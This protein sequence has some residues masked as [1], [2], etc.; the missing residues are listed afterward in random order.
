MKRRKT[1][2][3][4]IIY[5]RISSQNQEKTSLQQKTQNKQDVEVVSENGCS[6]LVC[7]RCRGAWFTST[8][9][10]WVAYPKGELKERKRYP[11]PKCPV[12]E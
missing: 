12:C 4:A 7:H 6:F 9:S 10:K 2:M 1:D 11:K 3:N 5:S 8:L